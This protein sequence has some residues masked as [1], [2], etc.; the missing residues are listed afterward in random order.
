MKH[1]LLA[2]ALLSTTPAL[3][4]APSSSLRPQARPEV[5]VAIQPTTTA[6][7]VELD[8]VVDGDTIDVMVDLGFWIVMEQRLRLY[9]VDTPEVFG[10]DKARGI[11]AS[12]FAKD[13]LD[14]GDDC[15]WIDT[16]R[17]GA[18]GKYGRTLADLYRCAD[19]V[20]LNQALINAGHVK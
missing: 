5:G 4:E 1:L 3:A 17:Y 13:W 12:V 16:R 18:K 6:F 8:R 2:L 19:P 11:E 15:L 9:D 7:S 10:T 20:S 14:E